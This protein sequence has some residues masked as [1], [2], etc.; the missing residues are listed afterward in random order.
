M[1]WPPRSRHVIRVTAPRVVTGPI[2]LTGPADRRLRRGHDSA[3]RNVV[4]RKG[5]QVLH[6]SFLT[7]VTHSRNH[8]MILLCT[9]PT[10]MSLTLGGLIEC[11]LHRTPTL[12]RN[13]SEQMTGFD[14]TIWRRWCGNR[15]LSVLCSSTP[16][17]ASSC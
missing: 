3:D 16:L 10:S 2:L 7:V 1:R 5:P 12:L 9:R 8:E 14:C 4:Y 6:S 15:P 13:T 17:A 11:R